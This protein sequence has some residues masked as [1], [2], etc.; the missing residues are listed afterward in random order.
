M[1]KIR[2]K[3]KTANMSK[4]LVFL[5]V[6]LLLF[7]GVLRAQ[8]T[9]VIITSGFTFVPA[10]LNAVV[11]DIIQFNGSAS[12]PVVQVSQASWNVNGSTP[13]AGGFSFPSGSGSYTLITAGTIYYVCESHVASNGMKG[14]IS[15]SIATSVKDHEAAGS[16]LYPVPANDF[17]Y[18]EP[19][20][21]M[22]VSEINILDVTGRPVMQIIRPAA[23]SGRYRID[24]SRLTKGI[25]ILRI[26]SGQDLKVRK[27]LKS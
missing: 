17:L 1:K 23:V 21:A 7:A 14:T 8:Q 25:Y 20:S 9:H 6:V 16:K 27:F 24:V 11:G 22:E 13:L 4:K 10:Q 3:T 5:S 12:H 2:N 18:Y 26:R 19:S 15:V